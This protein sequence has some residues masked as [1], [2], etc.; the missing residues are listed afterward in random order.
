M[1][2]YCARH[3]SRMA[4]RGVEMQDFCP[5]AGRNPAFMRLVRHMTPA[6]AAA[7]ASRGHTAP[8]TRPPPAPPPTN[9]ARPRPAPAAHPRIETPPRG[10]R[11]PGRSLPAT[12]RDGFENPGAVRV[13]QV[14]REHRLLRPSRILPARLV[15]GELQHPHHVPGAGDAHRAPFPDRLVTARRLC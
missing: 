1:R 10:D 14:T 8:R 15:R 5:L 9:P 4:D 11:D 12:G 13:E 7:T 2:L 6:V 3:H